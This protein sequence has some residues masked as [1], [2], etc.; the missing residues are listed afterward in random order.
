MER[1]IAN[2]SVLRQGVGL[3]CA[4]IE[5]LR[6]KYPVMSL[7]ELLDLSVSGYYSWRDRR[8]S[9]RAQEVVCRAVVIRA[10]HKRTRETIYYCR[11]TSG[12]RSGSTK[13]L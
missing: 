11:P 7:C 1:D 9:Q 13:D 4:M 2:Y 10:V 5:E 12:Q 6:I 8:P 3:R